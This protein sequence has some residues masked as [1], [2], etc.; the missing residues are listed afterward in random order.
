[1]VRKSIS[2]ANLLLVAT[3]QIA[4]ADEASERRLI[5]KKKLILNSINYL[6][7]E[8]NQKPLS[9]ASTVD[10][11][12]LPQ[13]APSIHARDGEG[14]ISGALFGFAADVDFRTAVQL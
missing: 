1:M 8:Q 11:V 4:F 6:R 12:K 14:A 9:I 5:H 10:I 3:S 2:L 13:A 7:G